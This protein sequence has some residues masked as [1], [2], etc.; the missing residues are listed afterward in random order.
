MSWDSSAQR[1]HTA[2]SI[3]TRFEVAENGAHICFFGL[4]GLEPDQRPMMMTRRKL[5]EG[6]LLVGLTSAAQIPRAD[7]GEATLPL[8]NYSVSRLVAASFREAGNHAVEHTARML[9]GGLRYLLQR[10]EVQIRARSTMEDAARTWKGGHGHHD[11]EACR[12]RRQHTCTSVDI[13]IN[14][15]VHT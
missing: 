8:P 4:T 12:R 10:D 13:G 5:E 2:C 7:G 9:S 6:E 1:S 14:V 3:C 15:Q 11:G